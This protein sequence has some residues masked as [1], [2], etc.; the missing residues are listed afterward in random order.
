MPAIAVNDLAGDNSSG[1]SWDMT[2]NLCDGLDISALLAPPK[3]VTAADILDDR[4]VVPD[5]GGI[6]GWWFNA[7]LPDVPTEGTQSNEGYRLLYVGIAPRAPSAEG[8]RSS[9]TLRKR[10][11]RNHLASRIASSTLRRSLAWILSE[12]LNLTINRN[13][14]GKAT[15]SRD[16]EARL[17]MWMSRYAAVS[18]LP[19]ESAWQ[20]EQALVGSGT[21][22]LPINIKGA[23]HEFKARLSAM[24]MGR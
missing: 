3:L 18:F 1:T 21:P 10:I 14:A 4:T 8:S 22:T 6:Y 11:V 19:H 13:A 23:G 5:V 7:E 9:S 20:I 12:T 15:M 16:D 2:Y 17:T 24:R